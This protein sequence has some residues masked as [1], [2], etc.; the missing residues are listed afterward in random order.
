MLKKAG[1]VKI[2]RIEVER[3]NK[4]VLLPENNIIFVLELFETTVNQSRLK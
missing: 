3:K 2:D 1:E 4:R